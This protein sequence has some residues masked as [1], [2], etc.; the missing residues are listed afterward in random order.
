MKL[1]YTKVLIIITTFSLFT[2]MS[3]LQQTKKKDEV[4]QKEITSQLEQVE[5]KKPLIR[6]EDRCP[7]V[8]DE[9]IKRDELLKE[10]RKLSENEINNLNIPNESKEQYIQEI[11]DTDDNF[12]KLTEKAKAEEEQIRKD[13]EERERQE[14]ERARQEEERIRMEEERRKE[15]ERRAY[16]E[17]I[18]QPNTLTV[19]G[20]SFNIAVGNQSRLDMNYDEIV[21]DDQGIGEENMGRSKTH[22]DG[23]SWLAG[24]HDY[25]GGNLFWDAT[26]VIY[27]DAYG[28]VKT[29][30]LEY[31]S[32]LIQYTPTIRDQYYSD[33]IGGYVPNR[34][35]IKTCQGYNDSSSRYYVFREEGQP[36]GVSY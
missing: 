31:T 30:Y 24:I 13:E 26:E 28:N 12:D 2:G 6:N 9:Q 19:K 15:D 7:K 35:A 27:A 36:S 5:K 20:H 10:K 14:Q 17:R 4:L 21:I 1:I 16:E 34:I 25:N 22:S 11:K 23:T 3:N 33:L 29:Y 8:F 32:P 18:S